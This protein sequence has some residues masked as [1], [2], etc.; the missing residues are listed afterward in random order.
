MSQRKDAPGGRPFPYMANEM[1]MSEI[2]RGNATLM[3]S[4]RKENARLF[5]EILLGIAF[6]DK[7]LIG[8]RRHH[9]VWKNDTV[10]GHRQGS[11]TNGG[12]EVRAPFD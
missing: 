5:E 9:F 8:E 7:S 4:M 12:Y 10:V 3:R 11:G 6:I 1:I 2:R